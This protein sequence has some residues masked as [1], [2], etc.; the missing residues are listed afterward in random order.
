MWRISFDFWDNWEALKRQFER[1]RLWA[2]YIAEGAWPDAD[3]LPI[4]KIGI[5]G[6]VGEP[7]STYFTVDEQTTLM[8]LW[9]IFRSPL[10][11]GGHL[12]ESDELSLKQ[13]TNPEA[14]AVNQQSVHNRELFH[15]GTQIGWI[16]D[17][18]G[19]EDAYLARF[20]TGDAPAE[21]AVTFQ[22]MGLSGAR[23]EVRDVWAQQSL[24][25]FSNTFRVSL[26]AH[27][28]GLYR[29]RV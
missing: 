26:N 2:P 29:F 1:C 20:N 5:R 16:A 14:I 3:M 24:G 28:A 12:P 15:R 17:V 13:I 6:E 7:R 25:K 19:S 9:C 21:E 22:E 27:G 11:F 23:C 4:G 8:T 10:M 18:P